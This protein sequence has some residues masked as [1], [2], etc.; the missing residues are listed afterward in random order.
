MHV[1][2]TGAAGGIGRW[3]VRELREAG[4]TVLPI[5]QRASD[6]V[7]GVSILD[8]ADAEATIHALRGVDAVVHLAAIPGP[9]MPPWST[10]DPNT[11]TTYHVLEAVREHRIGRL[12]MAS[13]IWAYGYNPP[14]EERIPPRAPLTEEMI[15]PTTN[16]YGLSKRLLEHLGQEYASVTGCQVVCMRYPWV[17]QP[18]QLGPSRDDAHVSMRAEMWSYVDVRDVAL[19]CRLAVE[20]EGLGFVTLNIAAADTRSAVPS[21][22]LVRRYLPN[23]ELT[24]PVPGHEALYSIDRARAV[25]GYEPRHT[26]RTT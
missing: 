8:L 9:K 25:L 22:D 19:A 4:H 18:H 20:H 3:V 2:V 23:T 17:A 24:R 14:S 16:C 5:D 21:E 12:V 11:V 10:F 1:A 13:S 7:E 26:W 6:Q 15:V